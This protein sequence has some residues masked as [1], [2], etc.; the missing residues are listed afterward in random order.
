[1]VLEL[2]R[3][4]MIVKAKDYHSKEEEVHAE[5]DAQI[6]GPGAPMVKWFDLGD[7][8]RGPELT[9]PSFCHLFDPDFWFEIRREYQKCD[10]EL[11][12]YQQSYEPNLKR[13]LLLFVVDDELAERFIKEPGGPAWAAPAIADALEERLSESHALYMSII[14]E[15]ERVMNELSKELAL[16]TEAVENR[17][18]SLGESTRKRLFGELQ[19]YNDRLSNLLSASDVVSNLQTK[20]STTAKGA[21]DVPTCKFWYHTD[22][23]YKAMLDA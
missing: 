8:P 14:Q 5:S 23:L 22:R 4:S 15:M 6:Y 20:R 18:F 21:I 10:K 9:S 12:Y 11:K 1:M 16:D 13:L 7:H 3:D 17:L 2:M 19:V